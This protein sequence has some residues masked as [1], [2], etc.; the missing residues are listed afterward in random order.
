MKNLKKIII[1]ILSVTAIAVSVGFT[2]NYKAKEVEKNGEPFTNINVGEFMSSDISMDYLYESGNVREIHYPGAFFIKVN[3]AQFN[4]LPGDYVTVSNPEGTEVYTYYSDPTVEAREEN[5][6]YTVDSYGRFW[7][8]TI[9]GDT[10]IVELHK[11]NNEQSIQEL[12]NYGVAVTR[13]TRGYQQAEIEEKNPQLESICGNDDSKHAACYKT[14]YPTI[15][16]QAFAVGVLVGSSGSKF[17]TGWRVGPT[18]T[19]KYILTNNHC[20]GTAS[21]ARSTEVW[22][23]YQYTSC[24][25]TQLEPITKV[26]CQDLVATS[27]S[28]DF[29]LVELR[30]NSNL[31]QYGYLELDVRKPNVGE[32]MYILQHPNAGVTK[33]AIESDQDAGGACAVGRVTSTRVYYMCDTRPGS[34]G[35]AVLSMNTR[36]VISL[37]NTGG[38]QNGST[39]IDQIWPQISKYFNPITEIPEIPQN[40]NASA[41]STSSIQLDWDD[42]RYAS[43]Y[44]VYRSK[45]NSNYA[46]VKTVYQSDFKDTG[47]DAETTYYYK[48]KSSNTKGDSDFSVVISKKTKPIGGNS[49]TS[50]VPAE[51][52]L[53]GTGSEEMWYIDVPSGTTLMNTTLV[54]SGNDIDIYGKFM[55]EPTASSYDWRGYEVGNENVNFNNPSS[56]RWYIMARS[57]SGMG[58]YTIK[59]TLSGGVVNPDKPKFNTYTISPTQI[60]EGSSAK[61]TWDVTGSTNIVASGLWQG[62]KPASGTE[63]VGS[64][65][66][67]GEYEFTLT[68]QNDKGSTVKTVR[69]IV[70]KGGDICDPWQA[71]TSYAIGDCVSYNGVD[72][73]CIQAHTA[74][75]GWTPAAVPSLWQLK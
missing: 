32:K 40:L 51:S 72:Y 14:T 36:K 4:L 75:D 6:D 59:C 29:S 5:S 45:T 44:K 28:L 67:Q 50:G 57:Y 11:S 39:R 55:A 68:A 56:G 13:F 42:A 74:I 9:F 52:S 2:S 41:L 30:P 26:A 62:S 38:C 10:A 48:L 66:T 18:E 12:N 7:A 27:S 70:T 25:S 63:Y 24:N 64:N 19:K 33:I 71:G 47:L 43:S 8:M 17:C 53:S 20:I 73:V 35:S 3:F 1:S 46:F 60:N 58:S 54:S 69:L 37:H 16:Q 61:I 15:Y 31:D 49:L 23:G 34:S 22:F 65:L 21:S